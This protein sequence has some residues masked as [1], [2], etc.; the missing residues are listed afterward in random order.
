M[1]DIQTYPLEAGR[2]YH[3]RGEKVRLARVHGGDLNL[4][5]P[6]KVAHK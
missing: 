6:V 5:I 2:D 4:R 1:R 3:A